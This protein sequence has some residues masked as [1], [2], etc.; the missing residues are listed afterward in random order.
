MK[1]IGYRLT[2]SILLSALMLGVPAVASSCDDDS[3][4]RTVVDSLGRQITIEGPID[5]IISMGNYR[6]EAV[7]VLGAADKLVG[8][9]Q[10]S[11]DATNYFSDLLNLPVVGSW[12]E[13]DY[14]MIAELDPD[15]VITSAHSGRVSQMVEML[16]DFDIVVIGLDFYR[17]D[18]I[19]TEVEKLGYLLNEEERAE[20]YV[21]WREGYEGIIEDTVKNIDESDLPTV[22]IEWSTQ[23]GKTYGNGSSGQALCDRTGGINVAS[24]LPEYPTVDME[25]IVVEDPQIIIKNV[26]LGGKWG[27][28]NTEEPNQIIDELKSRPG[29]E[30]VAAVEDEKVYLYCSEIA[31]G[32]DSIVL[33]AY[34]ARWFHPDI[35]I[36]PEEIYREY[37]DRFMGI[38]YPDDLIF[39][40]P[41]LE[42]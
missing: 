35:D 20:D 13:P 22:Y 26:G 37:L 4:P 36:N 42:A 17:D 7:K 10:N 28:N 16:D 25:W 24:E 41:P 9:D 27:W 29:W 34:S 30:K 21:A 14:E 12:S 32:L 23:A 38:E 15:I 33:Q 1:R 18:I 19:K 5:R 11:Y 2:V 31:W 8:I 3:Y 6:T 40:Y 39:V